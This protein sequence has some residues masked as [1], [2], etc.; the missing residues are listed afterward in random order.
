MLTAELEQRCACGQDA[1]G[2]TKHGAAVRVLPADR[3][4]LRRGQR[5]RHGEQR[6]QTDPTAPP[7]SGPRH[8]QHR[9]W[10][11]VEGTGHRSPWKGVCHTPCRRAA[12]APGGHVGGTGPLG[13]PSTAPVSGRGPASWGQR[14]APE[15][16]ERG[17]VQLGAVSSPGLSVSLF[18]PSSA[19]LC[20]N[21]EVLCWLCL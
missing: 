16:G 6:E 17:R 3:Q 9:G 4:R 7:R 21:R 18:G 12:S 11:L 19:E 14:G 13:I 10:M 20:F 5:A 2:S 8:A 1:P 15:K